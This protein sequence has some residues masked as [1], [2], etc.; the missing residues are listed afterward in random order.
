MKNDLDCTYV[1]K[2]YDPKT[3]AYLGKYAM[4]LSSLIG[5]DVVNEADRVIDTTAV[6]NAFDCAM[7]PIMEEIK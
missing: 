2:I 1:L 4:T 7:G 3:G 5:S 6:S